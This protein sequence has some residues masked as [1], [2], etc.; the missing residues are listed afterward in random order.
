M[1]F[2][3]LLDIKC[4]KTNRVPISN[5][6]PKI[7]IKNYNFFKLDNG[8][9]IILIENNK[10]PIIRI[11]LYFDIEPI[12]ENKIGI[13]HIIKNMLMA[14]SEN[15]TKEKLY[16]TLEYFG[17]NINISSSNIEMSILSKNIEISI[18]ILSDIIINP[19][20]N[21]INELNNSIK[22][23][24][25]FLKSKNKDI[26]YLISKIKNKLF[27]GINHP[28]G[29]IISEESLQNITLNDIKTFYNTY[30]K[31]N[32][33]YLTFIGNF[34]IE[35]IKNLVKKYF[36]YWKKGLLPNKNYIIPQ[37]SQLEIDLI[38]EPTAKK[39]IIYMGNPISLETMNNDF[40][41]AQ[42][43]NNILG[44]GPNSR[45]FINIRENKKYAYY[46]A[47]N[48]I[49][50]DY[51]TIF[52]LK[53]QINLHH[54]NDTIN[55]LIKELH[56]I[57]THYISDKELENNKKEEIGHFIMKFE[58]PIKYINYIINEIKYPKNFLKNYILNIKNITKE[59]ILETAKKY[60]LINYFRIIIIGNNFNIKE[61]KKFGYP[62]YLYNTNGICNKKI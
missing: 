33:A 17:S 25:I 36:S 44:N 2:N 57:T 3:E 19:N 8:L 23:Y 56:D 52:S 34:S 32:I 9:K 38:N 62:I 39:A 50:N 58:N 28:Y 42:M 45:L 27:Y 20:L 5:T 22:K 30:Y 10:F 37:H 59:Q 35:K 11:G 7:N 43:V 6:L 40:L 24:L 47:S 13:K 4:C 1:I 48:I 16:D 12:Q 54:V 61:M 29:Q 21:S 46:I 51:K 53:T 14:G 15:Y 49:I 31:P 55:L 41:I 18:K 60:F 26:D